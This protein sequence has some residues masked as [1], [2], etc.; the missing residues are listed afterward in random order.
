[1]F[2][3]QLLAGWWLS[4]L[5]TVGQD[6]TCYP[7]LGVFPQPGSPQGTS[8]KNIKFQPVSKTLK[9]QKQVPQ[10][11]PKVTKKVPKTGPQDTNLMKTLKK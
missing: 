3:G 11:S 1:M 5:L 8:Q 2:A 9:K 10:R 4:N 7:S 6:V